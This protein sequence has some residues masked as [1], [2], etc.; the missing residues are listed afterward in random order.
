M[1]E[2]CY[3]ILY[4]WVNYNISLT[5]IKAIWGWFPLLTMIPVRENSEV[6]IIYPYIYMRYGCIMMLYNSRGMILSFNYILIYY[7]IIHFISI[8]FSYI[9]MGQWFPNCPIFQ[10]PWHIPAPSAVMKSSAAQVVSSCCPGSNMS[11]VTTS[12]AT[13]RAPRKTCNHNSHGSYVGY[14]ESIYSG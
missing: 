5:W 12:A 13:C 2:T 4:I 11:L 3:I 7:C 8:A 9:Y 14:G 6:V 1:S 10:L